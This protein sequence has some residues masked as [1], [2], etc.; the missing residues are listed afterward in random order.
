MRPG[1]PKV[2]VHPMMLVVIYSWF[3]EKLG[4]SS[5][6]SFI[7][8]YILTFTPLV[9]VTWM[10]LQTKEAASTPDLYDLVPADFPNL[11]FSIPFLS[12]PGPSPK[13]QPH[14]PNSPS[15][16]VLCRPCFSQDLPSHCFLCLLKGCSSFKPPLR[17]TPFM[18]LP[19][20]LPQYWVLCS[21]EP[22][23]KTI[24][25]RLLCFVLLPVRQV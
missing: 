7:P 10:P 25:S 13:H 19:Q 22:W 3:P 15:F 1:C 6:S 21:I 9:E 8:T 24:P 18:R 5:G 17:A 14:L 4:P 2:L 20:F 11:I 23:N 16:F 12:S